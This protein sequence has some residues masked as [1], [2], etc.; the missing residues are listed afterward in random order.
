[1]GRTF[2]RINKRLYETLSANNYTVFEDCKIEGRTAMVSN[3]FKASEL[4]DLP[5]FKDTS[6]S[7]V[8]YDK[9]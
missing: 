2:V 5:F 8:G 3:D 4:P 6:V 9:K 7:G 1:M